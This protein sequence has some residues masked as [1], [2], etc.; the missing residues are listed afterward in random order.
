MKNKCINS[1]TSGGILEQP[2]QG[3]QL[4]IALLIALL[5]VVG[6]LLSPVISPYLVGWM[7]FE[8]AFWDVA[9]IVL[10]ILI[11][12]GFFTCI[13]WFAIGSIRKLVNTINNVFGG[14][15]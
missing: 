1:K 10:T 4:I 9:E 11:F 6:A 5:G 2:L 15:N 7:S 3:K 8:G 12:L 14:K 13:I